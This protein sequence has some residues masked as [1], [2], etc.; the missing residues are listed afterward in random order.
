MNATPARPDSAEDSR[1]A[2]LDRF[3]ADEAT[4]LR[5][6]IDS[7]LLAAFD[8]ATGASSGADDGHAVGL[9]DPSF[10]A[11]LDLPVPDL[12][13]PAAIFDTSLTANVPMLDLLLDQDDAAEAAS[14]SDPLLMRGTDTYLDAPEFADASPLAQLH[15]ND[16]H[17]LIAIDRQDALLD[18][19]DLIEAENAA[20]GFPDLLHRTHPD[21]YAAHAYVPSF[22]D[23][24]SGMDITYLDMSYDAR[25]GGHGG[26]GGGGSGGALTDYFAGSANG[27][28]GFDIWIQFKG[29]E[30]SADLQTAFKNAADYF[31]T[32][33]VDDVGGGLYR[34]KTIDDLY[35][36]AELK[37]IDGSGGVLGQSGPTAVW[38]ATD[39]TAAGQMQFDT[40]DARDFFNLGLWDEIV[41]HEM[42]HVLGFGSLW[43]YDSHSLVTNYQYTGSEALAAYQEINPTAAYIPVESDGGSGTAGAHWDEDT[44]SNELMTGYLDPADNY[45]SKYSVMSL[46]DLGY[47]VNYADYPYDATTIA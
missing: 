9:V 16:L 22:Y 12:S 5:S 33:I 23:H 44:L 41:T 18:A 1:L 38:S 19:R 34:G 27:D 35:L 24:D 37:A 36:T 8:T 3:D 2:A 43:N 6:L 21:F 39:L 4:S 45:M 11:G 13:M 46:G 25:G 29:T 26:G 10:L 32:I 30:W 17:G 31:T 28:A 20:F 47:N 42:M 40:A 15:G 7:H 14:L